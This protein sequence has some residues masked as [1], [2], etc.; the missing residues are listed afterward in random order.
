[1]HKTLK[2]Q[3]THIWIWFIKC[4]LAQLSLDLNMKPLKNYKSEVL[5]ELQM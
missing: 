4:I 2:T 3:T 1:M 5:K